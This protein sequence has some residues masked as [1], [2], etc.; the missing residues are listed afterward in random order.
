MPFRST[1]CLGVAIQ[2]ELVPPCS[3]DGSLT[4]T[5]T[6]S[7][8]PESAGIRRGSGD[9]PVTITLPRLVPPPK[10]SVIVNWWTEHVSSL[11]AH[12]MFHVANS[13]R[14]AAEI[15]RT[16]RATIGSTCHSLRATLDSVG[17]ALVARA[18]MIDAEY[19]RAAPANDP[20]ARI[21][22][23]SASRCDLNVF[24]QGDEVVRGRTLE[25][26]AA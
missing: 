24:H 15:A 25:P 9:V 3:D 21:G 16:Q 13:Y 14:A 19:D 23:S 2:V 17:A 11:G 6:P 10:D 18:R 7:I 5:P 8:R 1:D 22:T 20:V 26:E 12:E 4:Q